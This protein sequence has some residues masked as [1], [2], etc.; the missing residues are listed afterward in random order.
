MTADVVHVTNLSAGS[1]N[2][3]RG[4]QGQPRAA[5]AHAPRRGRDRARGEGLKK[6][7]YGQSS[8]L[9]TTVMVRVTHL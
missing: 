7:A 1:D 3:T 2:P 4:I 8:N 5:A 9:M 6:G